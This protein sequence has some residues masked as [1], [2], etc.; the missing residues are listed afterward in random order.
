MFFLSIRLIMLRNG[1]IVS[2]ER[3]SPVR[4]TSRQFFNCSDWSQ[5]WK[6]T[7]VVDAFRRSPLFQLLCKFADNLIYQFRFSF[8]AQTRFQAA[9]RFFALPPFESVCNSFRQRAEG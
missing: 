9:I 1:H 5:E 8:L 3:K 6:L 2:I 7:L 4:Q